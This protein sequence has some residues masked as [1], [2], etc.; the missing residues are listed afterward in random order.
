MVTSASVSTRSRGTRRLLPPNPPPSPRPVHRNAPLD[1]PLQLPP[2]R[3]QAEVHPVAQQRIP[4]ADQLDRPQVN[5]GSRLAVRHVPVRHPGPG[6]MLTPHRRQLPVA[7]GRDEDQPAPL[8]LHDAAD[9]E[10]REVHLPGRPE[11][12]GTAVDSLDDQI[13]LLGQLPATGA[14]LLRQA[15]LG[16]V[17]EASELQGVGLSRGRRGRYLPQVDHPVH[18]L[19]V[20]RPVEGRH[21]VRHQ[22]LVPARLDLPVGPGTEPVGGDFL[23]AHP[24]AAADVLPVDHQ[25]LAVR[26]LARKVYPKISENGGRPAMPVERMLRIYFLQLWFNLSD[27]GVEETLYDS[28]AMRSFVGIDLGVEGVPDETTGC[29]FRH[30]LERH[31]LGKTLLTAVND[32]LHRS[33]IRISKGTIVDATIIGAPS[34]TKLVHTVL[35]SAANVHDRD[36]LPYLLHG[37]EARVWGDQ[38]YQGQT[39]VIRARAPRAKDFTN[40]RYRHHG[41]INAIEKAKNRNKSRVRAKVEHVFGVI[42]NIFGFRKVCYRGLAKNLHRLEVTAALANPYLVRRRLLAAQD[43]CRCGSGTAA[44]C[45][46]TCRAGYQHSSVQGSGL[47]IIAHIRSH[48]RFFRASL[49]SILHN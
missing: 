18:R 31:Q 14:A 36:A 49:T 32:H 10:L 48:D 28:V 20:Q 38:G 11:V 47:K 3:H 40:R 2:P 19:P 8:G 13:T 9:G 6:G 37:K 16:Q 23:G 21:P 22:L 43:T 29:K 5:P 25:V 7:Q 45:S 24:H 34:S 39:A 35:A 15:Q 41:N 4:P 46:E 12:V 44:L 33:G 42:K 1:P 26:R 30:L 27:P 17:G